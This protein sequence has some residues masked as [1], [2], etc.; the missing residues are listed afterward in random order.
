MDR[1]LALRWILLLLLLLPAACAETGGREEPG[2]STAAVGSVRLSSDHAALQA[3]FEWARE[4][5]LGY[6]RS[7]DPVGPWFEA[8]LPGRDAFCMRDVSHQAEG[9]LALGLHR[10][11]LN[12]TRKFAVSIS[13]SR[14]WCGYW[15]IDRLDRP[16]P[17][18]YRNDGDFWYNL[19]ANF[20]LLQAGLRAWEWTWD[21]EWLTDPDLEEFRRRTLSDYVDRWDADGDGLV[22]S[23]ESAGIRGIPT[24]W[25]GGGPTPATGGDLVA[26]QYAANRAYAALLRAGG[27]D[28]AT[29]ARFDAEAE[30][31][32]A[33]Y[34]E[35][36][37]NE[38]LG[39]F[40]TSVLHDGSFDGTEIPAMQIFPLYFGIV[41]PHRAD[42]L[43]GGLQPGVNVEERSYLAE[44]YY[45][46]GRNDAAFAFL[47]AQMEPD[48]A[49]REYPENPF[50][51]VG[52]TVRWLAGVRPLA[53]EDL[54]E[55]RPRLPAEVGWLELSGVPVLAGFLDVHHVGNA[56]TRLTNRG[57][58]QVRWRAVFPGEMDSLQ[59]DGKSL[60]ATRRPGVQGIP[61][62][63]VLLEIGVGQTR[64]VT[65]PG[66]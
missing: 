18:D 56:S 57:D 22:Q 64:T 35:D 39:R 30:R 48:L 52:G 36:W 61:E 16:A 38:E 40:Q 24:Y 32:R 21:P 27:G 60:A 54:V 43:L 33:L 23:S 10:E 58:Q 49:R 8:A 1:R 34:N 62:S 17:V 3:G 4:T 13:D 45:R 46:Y 2:E 53:S 7:G 9:A 6:V 12:M 44:A 25:E 29:A 50:T 66:D 19:P 55:T 59:V 11:L 42:R 15:E 65:V 41:L 28:P 14:D 51:A 5:A 26:A 37:W 20:D 47:L 63:Y 31:L